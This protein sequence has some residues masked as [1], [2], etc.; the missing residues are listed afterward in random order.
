MAT[1]FAEFHD[2]LRSVAGDLLAKDRAVDWPALADAGWTGLEVPDEL[3]GA[4]ATFAEVAVVCEEMGRAAS[5]QQ[6]P[7][8]R[9]ARRRHPER[10]AAQ[11]YSRSTAGCT[12][13]RRS[14]RRLQGRA[15]AASDRCDVRPR[16]RRRRPAAAG[17]QRCR[18][19]TGDRRRRAAAGRHAAAGARRDPAA[20]RGVRRRRRRRRVVA[21]G[22]TATPTQRSAACSTAPRSRSRAT[23]SGSARQCFPR[24]WPTRRCATSSAGR[25]ARS[26][27]SSTPAPTCS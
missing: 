2:E 27:P 8:Q 9:R 12:D 21:R 14:G 26:R 19:C 15:V 11:R 6:L 16:R 18:R 1:E 5:A 13:D 25:S 10:V 23:A 24:P 20:G 4:G 3:G 7:R 17:R 22:S